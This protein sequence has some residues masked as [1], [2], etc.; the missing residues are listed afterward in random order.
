MPKSSVRTEE[1]LVMS[2]EEWAQVVVTF[3]EIKI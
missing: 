1:V 2:I 3:I